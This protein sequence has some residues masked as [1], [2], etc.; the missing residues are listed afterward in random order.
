MAA[1]ER[2]PRRRR[3]SRDVDRARARHGAALRAVDAERPS[4]TALR[5]CLRRDAHLAAGGDR[6]RGRRCPVMSRSS[7]SPR[8]PATE[9]HNL[10]GPTEASVDVDLVPVPAWQ[11]EPGPDRC[12]DLE[13]AGVCRST[14]GYGRNRW[15]CLVSCTSPVSSSARG[16]LGRPDLTA[17]K[18]VDLAL[19]PDGRAY[20]TGDL[21]RWTSAGRARLSG[22][23]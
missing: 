12:A 2:A 23:S 11:R 18:F 9:L 17:E 8:C 14:R 5:P 22:A 13:C 7:S 10:Y 6:A 3:T 21:V 1:P 4:S 16:Y 15:V 20:R 19:A